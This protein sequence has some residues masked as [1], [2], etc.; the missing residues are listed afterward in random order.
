MTITVLRPDSTVSNVNVNTSGGASAFSV[1]DDAPDNDATLAQGTTHRGTIFLTLGT[2]TIGAANRVLQA[3]V[4]GRISHE[5]TDVGHVEQVNLRL[6]DPT[7]KVAG[8]N[9]GAGTY[10]TAFSAYSAGWETTPPGGT[11]W[12]QAVV[13]RLQAIAFW[14]MSINGFFVRLSELFVDVDIYAQ[15]VVSAVTVTGATTTTRP[16]FS[17]TFAQTQGLPQ[18]ARQVKVFSAAQYGAGSFDP[19]TSASTWDSGVTLG[20]DVTGT[21]GVD[22]AN[23]TTYKVYVSAGVGWPTEQG[24][25]AYYNSTWVASSAFTIVLTPPITPTLTVATQTAAPVYRALLS[26]V[27]PINL[28]TADEADFETTAGSWTAETNC[29]VVRSTTLPANGVADLQLTATGAG[30]MSAQ[31]PVGSAKS[32]AASTDYT[33][34]AS[35]RSAVTARSCRV[36]LYWLDRA[37]SQISQVLGSTVTDGTGGYTQATLTATSPANAVTARCLVEVVSAAASEVHRVDMVSLHVGSSTTWTSGGMQPATLVIER[38][39]KVRNFRGPAVNWASAQ[40]A[41][42]GAVTLNSDGWYSRVAGLLASVP[43][44][45]PPVTGADGAAQ[46]RMVVWRPTVGAGSFLDFGHDSAAGYEPTPPY[47]TPA[48]VGMQTRVAVWAKTRSATFAA[49]LFAY[50]VDASNGV[51]T[52][53]NSGAVTLTTTW[54]RLTQDITPGAGSVWLRGAVENNTPTVEVDV[55]VTGVRICPTATDDGTTPGGQGQYGTAQAGFVWQTVRTGDALTPASPGE[56]FA[57]YDHELVPGRPMLYRVSQT[58]T[59]AGAVVS[60]VPSAPVAVYSAPPARAVLSDPFQPENTLVA[61]V[62]AGG[63]RV[64]QDEDAGVFHPL[65]SDGEPVVW[66][67]WIGGKDG[68]LSVFARTDNELYRLDQLHPSARPLLVQ[69]AQGGCT[70]IRITRRAQEPVAV[71]KGYW[72]LDVDYLE[73]GRP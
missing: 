29:S 27:A 39:E 1:L 31:V 4:R 51:V 11:A 14:L 20:P 24:L 38:A 18:D 34:I 8:R 10:T 66:R 21:V 36:K 45:G 61:R 33:V 57:V 23:G 26:I 64:S 13:D 37:G 41:S 63:M 54:Q 9:N 15:P 42:G 30:T 72:R 52:T 59:V 73:T 5:G 48:V 46:A 68:S 56:T 2:T 55:C 71:G 60:S 40:L 22:L 7:T 19:A 70:Y 49:R 62:L 28:L 44:D 43:I 16:D 25:G 6:Y 65:G 47:L 3:R 32:V 69:W 67:D 17:Y 35:F 53:A 50:A 12:T 58:V